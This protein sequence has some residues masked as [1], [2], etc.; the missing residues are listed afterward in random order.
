MLNYVLT[1]IE[2]HQELC[3][4]EVPEE[5]QPGFFDVLIERNGKHYCMS[6]TT[7]AIIFAMMSIGKSDITVKNLDE[8]A[9]R[10]EL[11]QDVRG[12]L[13]SKFVDG[14]S[15]PLRVTYADLRLHV[16]LGTNAGNYSWTWFIKQLRSTIDARVRGYCREWEKEHA[17]AL[18]SV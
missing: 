17:P 3:W 5:Y 2:N 18:Q 4:Q 14:K 13:L 15:Y 10:F 16:G 8:V 12:P 9:Q 7:T 1:D 6:A 11:L